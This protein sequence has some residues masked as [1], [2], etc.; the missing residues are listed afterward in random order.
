M[1]HKKIIEPET[2]YS[3]IIL[4]IS[5]LAIIMFLS[6]IFYEVSNFNF[7]KFYTLNDKRY[8]YLGLLNH[9][10]FLMP[11]LIGIFASKKIGNSLAV[12]I[13]YSIYLV[14]GIVCYSSMVW[15]TDP[16]SGGLLFVVLAISFSFI[17][18]IYLLSRMSSI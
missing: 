17:F 18:S 10:P 8:E 11:A 3:K 13:G 2:K 16:L 5:T 14:L 1:N 12:V 9:L 6:F 7:P 15:A 4:I